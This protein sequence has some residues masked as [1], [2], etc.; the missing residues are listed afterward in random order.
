MI[1]RCLTVALGLALLALPALADTIVTD[2]GREIAC[3][4]VKESYAKIEYRRAGVSSSQTIDTAEVVSIEYGSTP[5]EFREGLKLQAEGKMG[6]AA[7]FYLTAAEDKDTEAFVRATAFARMGDCLLANGNYAEAIQY[8]DTLLKRFPDT[9]H[10]AAALLGKGQAQLQSRQFGSAGETFQQ[11]KADAEAK[12]FG[13]RWVLDANFYLLLSAE[14]QGKDGVVDGYKE[15]RAIARADYQDIANKCS[16]RLGRVHLANGRDDE[17]EAMFDE[18]IEA[19]AGTSD[20]I[21]AGAFNGRG[22]VAF[23]RALGTLRADATSDAQKQAQ[24]ER[25][26]EFFNEAL[27]DHL[28]VVVSYSG[29]R[30]EQ[31]EALYHAGQCFLNLSSLDP[32]KE[33]WRLRGLQLLK[34]CVDNYSGPWAEKA[35]SEL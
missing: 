20:E 34:R 28:R 10:L 1:S 15:L 17:A 9:R 8:Y 27:L 18:I 23:G 13:E 24:E 5:I 21:V 19:R 29:I 7:S 30:A 35:G 14:A 33:D 22:R 11:L 2:Q 16:L 26:A 12:G 3:R 32:E 25:A 6:E 31:P 4:I